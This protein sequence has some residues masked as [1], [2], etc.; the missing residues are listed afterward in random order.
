MQET[1]VFLDG[2]YSDVADPAAVFVDV[3]GEKLTSVATN[4]NTVGPQSQ[5][6]F[7][8]TWASQS[9]SLTAIGIPE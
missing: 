7:E 2:E 9:G 1:E 6:G 4:A 3:E 8:W 5:A